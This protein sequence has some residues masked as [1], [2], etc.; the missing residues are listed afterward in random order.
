MR[1]ATGSGDDGLQTPT[2]RGL[3]IGKHI[4]GHSVR[5]DHAGFV[6]DAKLLENMDCVLHGVPVGTGAHEHTDLY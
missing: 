6:R 3:G 4:V 2:H 1:S 5:R